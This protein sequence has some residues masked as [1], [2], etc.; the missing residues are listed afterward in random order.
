MQSNQSV[1]KMKEKLLSL[2]LLMFL[3]SGIRAQTGIGAKLQSA[4]NEL[5]KDEQMKFA[6]L[7]F[8]VMD[9]QTGEKVFSHNEN[10]GLAPA[11]TLKVVTSA[12]AYTFLGHDFRYP[13]VI[14]ITGNLNASG[15]V[16]GNLVISGSGDPTLGSN[17]WHST[18]AP[19]LFPEWTA[20]MD[21]A[22]VRGFSNGAE[23]ILVG[24]G[25]TKY[26]FQEGWIW[27]DIGNYY[28]AMHAPFNWNENYFSV[29]FAPGD[30]VKDPVK[31]NRLDPGYTGLIVEPHELF[32]GP[33]KS[34]DNAFVYLNPEDA[35][36]MMVGGTVPLGEFDFGIRASH[37]HPAKF[38]AGYLK[39]SSGLYDF[40]FP[41][42]KDFSIRKNLPEGF[43]KIYTHYSPP[44]DSISYHFLRQSI[45]LYG[46]AL[47]KAIAFQKAGIAH[48]D[49]GLVYVK[50]LFYSNG[51]DR[52]ALN[53]M[54]G[55]GLSPQN[56][57]TAKSLTQV[58]AYAR[59]Q[60]WFSSFYEGLPVINGMKMKSG[61]IYGARGYTGY[62]KSASGREYI[63]TIIV[64]NYSGS[65]SSISRKMFSVLNVL[66]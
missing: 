52:G 50:N 39:H 13:T 63:F 47:V 27:Q 30:K 22:G 28:G 16:E 45:N 33:E 62:H 41:E 49:T 60:S 59:K 57:V 48:T 4:V 51:V 5:L 31:V 7:G 56:R 58:L 65:G 29:H 17:R 9:A 43:K 25:S 64:N 2:V 54:D 35:S 6:T 66:N 61:S 42:V 12:A 36:K 34:G 40:K 10:T 14:G 38:F 37:P 1:Y 18:A 15:I 19:T 53:I 8:Y 46:E 20:A 3:V 32:T 26:T 24:E 11:S 21:A 23:T 44:L 55:S